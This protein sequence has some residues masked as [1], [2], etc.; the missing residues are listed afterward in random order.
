MA[1][2]EVILL[3]QQLVALRKAMGGSEKERETIQK[4]LD[5]EVGKNELITNLDIKM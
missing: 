1:D 2:Q 5:K 3:R 4:Q